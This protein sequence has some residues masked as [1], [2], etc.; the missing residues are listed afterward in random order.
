MRVCPFIYMYA[1]PYIS[2]L[3]T[4]RFREVLD[5]D[6]KKRGD[7]ASRIVLAN[8]VIELSRPNPGIN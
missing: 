6:R 5:T 1:R 2:K 4:L 3:K 8:G 7:H